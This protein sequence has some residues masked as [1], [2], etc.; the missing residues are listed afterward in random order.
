MKIE[1]DF[2]GCLLEINI[3][4]FA[5]AGNPDGGKRRVRKTL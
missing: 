2:A 1:D 5:L 3:D 4:A